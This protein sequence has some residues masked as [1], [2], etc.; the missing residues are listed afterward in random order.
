VEATYDVEGCLGEGRVFHVDAEEA[1]DLGGVASEAFGD[2]LSEAAVECEAHLGEL[3]ADVGVEFLRGDPLEEFVVDVGS[4]VGFSFRGNAFAERVECDEE[5]L[6]VEFSGNAEGVA[7]FHTGDE[8][9]AHATAEFGVLAEVAQRT[10]VG[11]GDKCGT[12]NG[13]KAIQGA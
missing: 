6:M 7:D 11:E 8:A 5:A 12:K 2:A 9:G 4:T 10:I 1:S 13:H 3:Y